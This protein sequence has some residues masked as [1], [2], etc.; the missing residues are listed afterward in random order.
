MLTLASNATKQCRSK[1]E[2]RS[3]CACS[4][5]QV[6][7]AHLCAC[8]QMTSL[9]FMRELIIKM[10]FYSVAGGRLFSLE[11]LLLLH[12]YASPANG[13]QGI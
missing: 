3:S 13:Q 7:K 5:A 8:M 2:S 4:I 12:Y 6:V 11:L 10:V 1:V 9:F